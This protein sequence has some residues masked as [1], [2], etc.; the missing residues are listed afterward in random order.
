MSFQRITT[1]GS[2]P[3]WKSEAIASRLDAVAL[4]LEPVDLVR[5]VRD[6][7]EVAHA[8]G[9]PSATWRVASSR[10]VREPLRLLHRRLD[11]VEAEVVRG[12]LGQVDDVVERRAQLEDVL[13]VDRRDERL[14]Q[15]LADDVVRDRSPSCSSWRIA[16]ES[17]SRRS[18]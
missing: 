18:G 6:V 7:A 1:I 3:S 17:S 16:A 2:M 15:A 13:A 11:A 5:E 4:V 14:V 8:A 9:S 10:I 12:L